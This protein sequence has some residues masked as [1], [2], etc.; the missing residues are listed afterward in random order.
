M[1]DNP[2]KQVEGLKPNRRCHM[3]LEVNYNQAQKEN[4]QTGKQHTHDLVHSEYKP[5]ANVTQVVVD[6]SFCSRNTYVNSAAV[7]PPKECPT[8]C[9]DPKEEITTQFPL[10]NNLTSINLEI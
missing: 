4:V 7:P 3:Q 9:G 6:N 2:T 8:I 5:G 1:S 10:K